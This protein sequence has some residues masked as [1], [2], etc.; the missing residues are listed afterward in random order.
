MGLRLLRVCTV[1]VASTAL[2]AVFGVAPAAAK[3]E[4]SYV[5]DLTSAE[6]VPGPGDPDGSAV[7]SISVDRKTESICFDIDAENVAPLTKGVIRHGL[8]GTESDGGAV[9]FD[10]LHPGTSKC[11]YTVGKGAAKELLKNPGEYYLEVYN[12]EYPDGALRGQLPAQK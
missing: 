9:L 7:V 2:V 8:A 1:A 10:R 11:P 4:T 3:A 5:F 12:D 6:V